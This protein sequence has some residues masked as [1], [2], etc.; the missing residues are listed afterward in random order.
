MKA[1]QVEQPHL[2][3]GLAASLG[4]PLQPQRLEPEVDLGVHQTAGMNEQDLH[5][6]DPP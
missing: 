3:A 4:H 1:T 5:G 6:A 2:V